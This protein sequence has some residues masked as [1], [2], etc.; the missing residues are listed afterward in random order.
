M[1]KFE[2]KEEFFMKEKVNKYLKN[3]GVGNIFLKFYV[4]RK[5]KL[6]FL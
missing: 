6:F 1:N 4:K 3:I 5:K 2:M